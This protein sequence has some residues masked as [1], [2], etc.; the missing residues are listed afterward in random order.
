MDIRS[1]TK[2]NLFVYYIT[3]QSSFNPRAPVKHNWIATARNVAPSIASCVF[4]LSVTLYSLACS[5]KRQHNRS[6]DLLLSVM[7]LCSSQ[8]L[9]ITVLLGALRNRHLIPLILQ[10]FQVIGRTLKRRLDLNLDLES[11]KRSHN[12]KVAAILAF[13]LVAYIG[14][15]FNPGRLPD[16]WLEIVHTCELFMVSLPTMHLLFYI[17]LLRKFLNDFNNRI[18]IIA[19][20][21]FGANVTS[22]KLIRSELRSWQNLHYQLWIC[23]DNINR[24]FSNILMSSIWIQFFHVSWTAYWVYIYIDLGRSPLPFI[25]KFL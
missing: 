24:Y 14:K 7:W 2:G 16:P 21:N 6:A 15:R 19:R 17:G 4:N 9:N 5:L 25:R 13:Q 11:F 3:G 1:L 22:H 23:S 20:L 18:S 10:D 12:R 8:L